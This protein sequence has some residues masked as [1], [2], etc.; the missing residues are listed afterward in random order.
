MADLEE[1]ILFPS[2]GGYCSS[3][4]DDDDDMKVDEVGSTSQRCHN[5]SIEVN[6]QAPR[7]QWNTGPKGVL[8]DYR[9]RKAELQKEESRKY[10]EVK[11]FFFIF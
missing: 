1:K 6:Q 4:D 7:N 3:S 11:P 9:I 10:E 8:E 5:E 2:K